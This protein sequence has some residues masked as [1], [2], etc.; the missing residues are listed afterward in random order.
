[1]AKIWYL[2]HSCFHLEIDDVRIVTDP[3][4]TENPLAKD[5][6][7]SSIKADI[8][9]V[10]HGHGDHIGDLVKLANQTDALVVCNYEIY[11]W[12]EKQGINNCRPMNHGGCFSSRGIEYKVVPAAHSSSFPDGSYAGNPVG[13]VIKGQHDVIYF[14]GDTGLTLDMKLIGEDYD[15]T[16]A[17]LPIG[18]NFTM[19]AKDAAKAAT[20]CGAKKVI[21]MHYDTFEIIE[22][23]HE[24]ARGEFQTVGVELL[25]PQVGENLEF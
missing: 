12:L 18:D 5:T 20:F 4:I 17:I 25:L 8:I 16:G 9:L 3:F 15:L 2:G 21:G 6:D 13:F 22:I 10:T 7:I 11:L 14:A 24:I 23:D 19:G 1:M